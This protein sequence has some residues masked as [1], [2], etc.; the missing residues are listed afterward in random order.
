MDVAGMAILKVSVTSSYE[1]LTM[2]AGNDL[3][4]HGKRSP[5]G[6]SSA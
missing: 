1:R 4:A 5:K 6:L 3:H 2:A